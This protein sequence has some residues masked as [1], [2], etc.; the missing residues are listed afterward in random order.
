MNEKQELVQYLVENGGRKGLSW[1][2]LAEKFNLPTKEVAR[3]TWRAYKKAT[4]Y[5]EETTVTE[6][7]VANYIADLEAEVVAFHEDKAKQTAELSYVGQVVLSLEQ[8]FE[9]AHINPEQW[10]VDKYYHTEAHGKSTLRVAL[11]P[12]SASVEDVVHLLSGYTSKYV[13]FTEEQL[14]KNKDVTEKSCAVIALSDFHIDKKDIDGSTIQ[15]HVDNYKA[16]TDQLL[17]RAY[18]AHNLEEIVLILG[19]DF[20]NTDNIHNATTNHTPQSVVS[21]WDQ[22]YEI[23]FDLM[24]DR[25]SRMKQFC[26]TLH[27]VFVPGNHDRTKSFYLTHALEVFFRGDKS[28]VFDRASTNR[29]VHIYGENMLCFHHGDCNNQ[30]LPMVFATEF[31]KE[32]GQCRHKEI[33]LGDKHHTKEQIFKYHQNEVN[34]VRMR[35][36]PSLSGTDKWHSDNLFVGAQ[37]AGLCLIYDK[38]KGKVSE[39]EERI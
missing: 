10:T 2:A 36:L 26:D 23:A 13:P 19:S 11:K 25:I 29:K 35:I 4:G 9:K 16:V 30:K 3:H 38:E 8:L 17:Q 39:F 24:V 5:K 34:G 31:Y 33:L 12:K 18:R 37:R 7:T 22:S 21:P 32:W 1:D 27:V 6:A 15:D 14:I 20:F 28:I